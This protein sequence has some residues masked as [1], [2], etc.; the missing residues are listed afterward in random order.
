MI[1]NLRDQ[2]GIFDAGDG[3][4]LVATIWAG[5]NIDAEYAL[6]LLHPFHRRGGFVI[7]DFAA[8]SRPL[9]KRLN[10]ETRMREILF[11][12]SPP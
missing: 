7:V 12:L 3:T 5:F 9:A 8:V 1:W 10:A 2:R 11:I 4:E 6:Q